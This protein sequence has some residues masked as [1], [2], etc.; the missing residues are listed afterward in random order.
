MQL[1]YF[2]V[3]YYRSITEAYKLN[4]SDLT[5]L[6]GKN[7][8]GKTNIIRAIDLGMNILRNAGRMSRRSSYYISPRI[9]NWREDFPVSLQTS[10][11]L[12]NKSTKIRMDFELSTDDIN[13]FHKQTQSSINGNLSIYIEID[14]N[15]RISI[16]VPKKGKNARAMTE[17]LYVISRFICMR[18]GVQYI[19]AIRSEEDA[20]NSIYRL[21]DDELMN[22]NDSEYIDAL[23]LINETQNN[24]LAALSKKIQ[25][26]LNT[27]LP[28]I[29]NVELYKEMGSP[30]GYL[31]SDSSNDIHI[32]IDDGTLTSLSN[33][34]DG[35]KSLITIAMLS[36]L[37]T[38]GQRL[39]IVDEPENH[40]HPEAIHYIDSVL[41]SLSENHQVL[42]STHSPIFVN[43]NHISSNL[44]VKDGEVKKAKNLSE[45]RDTLG[46]VCSDNLSDCDYIVLVEGDSD[47]EILQKAICEDAELEALMKNKKIMVKSMSGTHNIKA[48]NYSLQML[49][50]QYLYVLDYDSAGRTAAAVL[51]NELKLPEKQIKYFMKPNK[52]DTELE[53]LYNPAVYKDYLLSEQIDI[54]NSIFK[55]QS[56]KWSDKIAEIYE[57]TAAGVFSKDLECRIKMNIAEQLINNP[58]SKALTSDGYANIQGILTKIRMDLYL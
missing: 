11:K 3:N 24:Y 26:S 1:S 12:K 10:K 30:R 29:S 50:C 52:R 28:Q 44:I 57:K 53:D 22:I 56:R 35:V 18:F 25:A 8:T 49:C 15:N 43:R 36:Q 14:A 27:F 41:Q 42:I 58:L 34:G 6:L 31:D 54:N 7:N 55:N 51:N 21:L 23:R 39:I 20:Y 48:V 9:Y 5:V 47:K 46:I 17:K 45:I 13:D 4:L 40:L 2:S 37:S 32:D 38:R 19:K 33:K 16:T